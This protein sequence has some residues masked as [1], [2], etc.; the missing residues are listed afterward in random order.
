M[1]QLL[2]NLKVILIIFSVL[3]V[4]LL[5]GIVVQQTRS[6][7]SLQAAVGENKSALKSRYAQAGSIYTAD[8]EVLAQSVD[9]ERVYSEDEELAMAASQLVGDY[10]H[11]ISNTIETLYQ[12]YLTGTERNPLYQLLFDISGKGLEGDDVYLTLDSRLEK[13][14]YEALGD[15]N[16]SV[17]LLN[18]STGAVL[19]SVSKP[20][21]TMDDIVNYTNLVDTG[22]FNRAL[23]GAYFPGSAFKT[24]TASAWLSSASYD[25]DLTVLCQGATPIVPNGVM[26]SDGDGHGEVDLS[27]AFNVSCNAFFGTVGIDIGAEQLIDM[28]E[29]FGFNQPLTLDRLQ[30]TGSK[31]SIPADDDGVLSWVSIGQPVGESELTLSP[32]HMALIAAA[33]ANNGAMPQPHIVSYLSNPLD[34]NYMEMESSTLYT[35][36]SSELAGE[37]KALMID[38]VENGGGANAAVAGYQVGGKTGTPELENQEGNNAIFIGFLDDTTYPLAIAV[39]CEDTTFA[40]EKAAPVAAAVFSAAVSLGED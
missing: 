19:A 37:M 17:V 36:L 35:P 26:E 12:G 9:G 7:H 31:I 29:A 2:R 8:G 4:A 27:Q 24:I 38:E 25:P 18:Y 21:M 6:I 33:I 34:Q 14:A 28:A 1:K 13:A 22:L 23:S 5:A 30:V 32:L 11:N 3:T 16:G 15:L 10:T 20:A 40:A 39:V